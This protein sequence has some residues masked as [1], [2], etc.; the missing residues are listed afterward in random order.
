MRYTGLVA[1]LFGL[2]LFCKEKIEAQKPETFPRELEGSGGKIRLYRNHNHGFCFGFL[3]ERPELVKAVP[4]AMTS[5]AGGILTWL[6][7]HPKKS[8]RTQKLGF[9]L[10]TAG[11]LSN[12]FDRLFRGYVIDYFSFEVKGL[13]KVVFNLGDLFL[14]AGSLALMLSE[15]LSEDA[16]GKEKRSGRKH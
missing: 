5:A 7:T 4:L 10:V 16:P 1:G 6:L 9:T 13:K 14:F 2:D 8:T 12:L 11:G 15:L 3:K